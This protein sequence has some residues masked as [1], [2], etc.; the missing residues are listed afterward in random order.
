MISQ[1]KWAQDQWGLIGVHD[2]TIVKDQDKYYLFSTDTAVDGKPTA[3]AQI[4]VSADLQHW[5]YLRTALPG[6]PAV[7]RQWSQASGLWAPEVKKVGTKFLM[8]YSAST[9]GSRTSCIGLATADRAAGPWQDQGLVVKT[10]GQQHGQNA[11]DAN[12]IADRNG[13]YWLVYGSFFGGIYIVA[14]DAKTGFT[15]VANDEG[16]QIAQ[17]PSRAQDGAIEGCFIQYQ[18]DQDYYYLFMS[19]DS[20]TWSYHVRVARSREITGPY[21]D[22]KSNSVIYPEGTDYGQIGTKILGSYQF[23]E[24]YPWV[25]PGHNSIFTDDQQQFMVHHVRDHALQNSSYG[26]IRKLY[27]LNNG[28]PVVSPNFYHPG[29][30]QIQLEQ[31]IN[32][33]QTGEIIRWPATSELIPSHQVVI[34]QAL[35]D[36]LTSY[37]VVRSYDWE[38]AAWRNYLLGM[39]KQG[40]AV[41]LQLS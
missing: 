14:I 32:E 28:W 24:H 22:F 12:L 36:T 25:A 10:N 30:Q 7:A 26:F 35:L 17:R 19:Y 4:R 40:S 16:T 21:V 27:W 6:V 8:Y 38:L 13:D 5:Q 20:L 3:G 23:A 29:E 31:N 9:F 11:I 18:S 39:D 37:L 2:P 41:W 34:N 1:T 33:Q 15:K